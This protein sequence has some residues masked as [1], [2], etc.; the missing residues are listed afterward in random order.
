LLKIK[1]LYIV[2]IWHLKIILVIGLIKKL[3]SIVKKNLLVKSY[4]KFSFLNI[5]FDYQILKEKKAMLCGHQTEQLLPFFFWHKQLLPFMK[6]NI[7]VKIIKE[8][9]S[10]TKFLL[11]SYI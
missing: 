5:S 11:F 10:S 7:W 4:L 9:K 6:Q 3:Y 1:N 8:K 2:E